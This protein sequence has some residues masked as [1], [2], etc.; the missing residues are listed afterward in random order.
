MFNEQ[1]FYLF[2]LRPCL[3]RDQYFAKN[4]LC[5]VPYFIQIFS[6]FHAAGFTPAPCVNLRL[7]NHYRAA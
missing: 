2:A 3:V 7:Y 4:L 6:N 1:A 5:I